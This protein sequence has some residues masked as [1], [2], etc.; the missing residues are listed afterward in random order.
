VVASELDIFGVSAKFATEILV[1]GSRILYIDR[2][3]PH[4]IDS[5]GTYFRDIGVSLRSFC[6]WTVLLDTATAM[7]CWMFKALL[8]ATAIGVV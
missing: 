5:K 8:M 3:L 6:R 1:H 2:P 7:F 4:H